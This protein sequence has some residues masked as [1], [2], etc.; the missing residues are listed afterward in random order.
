MINPNILPFAIGFM[1]LLIM[2]ILASFCSGR[3]IF[4]DSAERAYQLKRQASI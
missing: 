4:Q 2:F 1:I 3:Y